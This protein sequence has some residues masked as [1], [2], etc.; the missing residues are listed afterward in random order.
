MSCCAHKQSSRSKCIL[1]VHVLITNSTIGRLVN[2]CKKQNYQGRLEEIIFVCK[3]KICYT[4][5]KTFKHI[6]QES[7]ITWYLAINLML[8]N[9]LLFNDVRKWTKPYLN[10]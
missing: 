5:Q 8:L 6:A 10:Q 7:I 3:L 4:H 1:I 2:Q 9:V